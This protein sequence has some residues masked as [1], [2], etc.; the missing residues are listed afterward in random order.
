M[1]NLEE[2]EVGLKKDNSQASLEGIIEVAV[3]QY[4]VQHQTPIEIELEVSSV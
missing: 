4:Q 2:V 1:I 3:D